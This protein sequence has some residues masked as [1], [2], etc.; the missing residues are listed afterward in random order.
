MD[1]IVAHKKDLPAPYNRD[2]STVLRHLDRSTEQGFVDAANSR[3][4]ASFLRAG[5]TLINDELGPGARRRPAV[6]GEMDSV[7]RRALEFLSQR[8]VVAQ[9]RRNDAPFDREGTTGA[10]RTRWRNHSH[11]IADLLRFGLWA[12]QYG[13]DYQ[14]KRLEREKWL[15]DQGRDLVEAIHVAAVWEL[16]ML[17]TMPI[18]RLH[19]LAISTA[20]GDDVIR[21]AIGENYQSVLEDWQGTYE[22]AFTARGLRPRPGASF[23]KLAHMLAAMAE[24]MSMR[25]LGDAYSPIRTTDLQ[26]L[27]G[28]GAIWLLLGCLQSDDDDDLR[29]AEDRLRAMVRRPR[30]SP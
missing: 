14:N 27:L 28:E 20:E 25:E 1:D 6:P 3:A 22:R 8:R 19:L 12:E 9:G 2:L 24:G 18:F 15:M 23:A 5:I 30:T 10:L 26:T 21:V 13:L 29:S 16:E 7:E 4:T 17:I 11:Y